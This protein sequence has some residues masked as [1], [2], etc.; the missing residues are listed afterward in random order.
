LP[1]PALARFFDHCA[2]DTP[3]HGTWDSNRSACWR[4]FAG[5]II[6]YLFG[7][8]TVV[9]HHRVSVLL[10]L[11]AQCTYAALSAG[12]YAVTVNRL[13]GHRRLACFMHDPVPSSTY[14]SSCQGGNASEST[15]PVV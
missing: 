9:N 4:Y 15:T 2:W 13:Y 14:A 12:E 11:D 1:P 7:V 10:V 3:K 5:M 8:T 6:G